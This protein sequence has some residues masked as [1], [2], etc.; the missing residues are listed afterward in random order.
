MYICI[1]IYTYVW[2]WLFLRISSHISSTVIS[3]LIDGITFFTN[4]MA[5]ILIIIC[6]AHASITVIM[7]TTTMTTICAHLHLYPRSGWCPHQTQLPTPLPPPRPLCGQPG[8]F[9]SGNSLQASL[10]GALFPFPSPSAGPLRA[11]QPFGVRCRR[12]PPPR[13]T[14][15]QKN[16]KRCSIG[17]LRRIGWGTSGQLCPTGHGSRPTDSEQNKTK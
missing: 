4:I 6:M 1:H 10:W 12:P 5:M 7:I 8:P 15:P 9:K 16:S 11:V 3:T 17:A 14:D 2:I 13:Q